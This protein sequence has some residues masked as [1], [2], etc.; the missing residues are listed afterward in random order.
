MI[1]LLADPEVVVVVK[2]IGNEDL[3]RLP[4]QMAR[5]CLESVG[6]MRNRSMGPGSWSRQRSNK[7]KKNF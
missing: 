6:V 4:T 7:I 1:T 5:R 2:D 3:V